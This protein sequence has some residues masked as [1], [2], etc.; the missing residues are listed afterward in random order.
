MNLSEEAKQE[1]ILTLL[2]IEKSKTA[3]SRHRY[4]G[5]KCMFRTYS[6]GVHFGELISKNGQTAVV[7]NAHRVHYWVKACSIS[8][9]AMEGDKNIDGC[10]IAMAVNEIELDRVIEVIP[11]TDDAYNNLT[12]NIWKK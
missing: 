9:L 10:R 4:F 7:K 11:M 8:Q 3:E 2:G 5:K 12:S 6:A 1:L